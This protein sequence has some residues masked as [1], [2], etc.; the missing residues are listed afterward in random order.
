MPSGERW[1]DGGVGNKHATITDEQISNV[2]CTTSWVDDGSRGILAH[3]AGT[4]IV[5]EYNVKFSTWTSP[6][7]CCLQDFS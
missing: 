7:A 4:E 5:Q 1:V 3:S 2:V 6:S